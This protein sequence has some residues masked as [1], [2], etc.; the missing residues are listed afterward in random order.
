MDFPTIHTNFWDAVTAIPIIIVLTQLIKIT[1]KPRPFWVPTIATILGLLLSIFVSHKGHLAT[2]IFM[3]FF[4]GYAAIGSFASMKT[5][6]LTYRG[7]KETA[8]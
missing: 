6:F 5:S 7:M 2:G 8:E 4:Y 1:I 3:G